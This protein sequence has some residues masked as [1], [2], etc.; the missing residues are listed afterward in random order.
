MLNIN[1]YEAI[2]DFGC[3]QGYILPYQLMNKKKTAKM[4][5]CDISNE[6]IYLSAQRIDQFLRDGKNENHGE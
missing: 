6:M 1:N 2:L 5:A 4:L 3:G